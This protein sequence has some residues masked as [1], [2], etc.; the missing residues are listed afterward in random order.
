M[1]KKYLFFL[2]LGPISSLLWVFWVLPEINER[3]T[4]SETL[5]WFL[6]QSIFPI[7]FALLIA[8]KQKIVFWLLVIYSGFILLFCIGMFGWAL[9]GPETPASIY[10]VCGLLVV[11]AFGLLFNTLKDLKLDQRVKQYETQD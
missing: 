3:G 5:Q 4:I 11:M 9:M 10:V 1:I 2:V 8:I 6:V 7:L